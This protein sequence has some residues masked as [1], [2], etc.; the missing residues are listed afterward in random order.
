MVEW[1]DHKLALIVAVVGVTVTPT[2]APVVGLVAVQVP[3]GEEGAI[4]I[5]GI[6]SVQE[7]I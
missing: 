2:R 6:R 3:D 5:E 7:G 4:E 1:M